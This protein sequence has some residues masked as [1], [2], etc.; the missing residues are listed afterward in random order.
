MHILYY[1]LI[2][3]QWWHFFLKWCYLL[4]ESYSTWIS[5]FWFILVY[6][7]MLTSMYFQSLPMCSLLSLYISDVFF[8]C[9]CF[10]C[11][12]FSS[13]IIC[14]GEEEK[15]VI[16]RFSKPGIMRTNGWSIISAWEKILVSDFLTL[17]TDFHQLPAWR[18]V[19]DFHQLRAYKKNKIKDL[20][21]SQKRVWISFD[22]ESIAQSWGEEIA[23]AKG[24]VEIERCKWQ[25]VSFLQ[26]HQ[27]KRNTNNKNMGKKTPNNIVERDR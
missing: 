14:R 4:D 15:K 26:V 22:Y 9:C 10:C 5:N 21:R 12:C 24:G 7:H 3:S 27:Q 1:I 19:P 13:I 6:L 16:I 25:H 23:K 11:F 2:K 20:C 17:K 8:F 18:T